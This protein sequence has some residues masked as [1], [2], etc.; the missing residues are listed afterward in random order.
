MVEEAIRNGTWVPPAPPT[1]PVRVDLTKKPVLW[2]AYIDGKGDLIGHAAD[3]GVDEGRKIN[4]V[5]RMEN[6]KEWDMIKPFAAAYLAPNAA[7]TN[8]T[9]PATPGT[10]MMTGLA[11][12]PSVVSLR[13][14]TTPQ[15]PAMPT[16]GPQTDVEAAN[17]P[18]AAVNA[19]TPRTPRH[20]ALLSRALNV[21]NP[22]P[23]PTSP[24][25]AP[26]SGPS[27]GSNA[28]LP[29]TNGNGEMGLKGPQVMRV[30]VL[31]AMPSPPPGAGPGSGSGT[32]SASGISST[33]SAS[34][35]TS[36]PPPVNPI[37]AQ[38]QPIAGHPLHPPA[39][40][41]HSSTLDDDDDEH[42]LPHL[43]V[44]VAEVLVVPSDYTGGDS[45][46]A[47]S[48]LSGK[49]KAAQRGSLGSLASGMSEGSD[50]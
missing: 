33:S 8:T 31:I 2:E 37:P 13:S 44:G 43:E 9:G 12:I 38:S 5:W 47:A 26:L 30:A 4:D 48:G 40:L 3:G 18:T 16:A 32:L 28:N 49:K 15:P 27:A 23:A 21:L 34:S 24:L 6:S 14:T 19:A 20:R 11:A 41:T 29:A 45:A 17:G 22:T 42:P 25:P 46:H 50:L 39:H 1:R 36:P 7:T 35:S 10:P